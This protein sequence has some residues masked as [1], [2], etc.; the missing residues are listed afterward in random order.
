M[1]FRLK[2]QD[3]VYPAKLFAFRILTPCFGHRIISINGGASTGCQRR[4]LRSRA[5]PD[6]SA[7]MWGGGA[8]VIEGFGYQCPEILRRGGTIG[9]I[10]RPHLKEF[11]AC[12]C[13]G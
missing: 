6:G 9:P 13:V 10:T 11:R 12:P 5:N 8:M 3:M 4:K 7:G 1:A 2:P